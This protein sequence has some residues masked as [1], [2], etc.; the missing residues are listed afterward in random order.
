[1]IEYIPKVFKVSAICFFV[2][3]PLV[4]FGVVPIVQ[5]RIKKPK[6]VIKPAIELKIKIDFSLK[7]E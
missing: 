5:N 3:L 4:F 6:T 1:M 7:A 2:F